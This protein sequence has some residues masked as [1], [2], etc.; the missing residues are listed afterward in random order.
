MT[1]PAARTPEEIELPIPWYKKPGGI[2]ALVVGALLVAG[3]IFGIIWATGGDDDAEV[4]TAQVVLLPKD[5][6]GAGLDQGF[7][8]DVTGTSDFPK[9]YIWL[10]PET[11]AGIEGVSGSSGDSDRVT[12]AWAPAADVTEPRDWTSTITLVGNSP[13]GFTPPGPVVECVLARPDEQNTTVSMDVVSDP[14][15]PLVEQVVTYTFPNHEFLP[16]DVVTCE[17]VSLELS[18]GDDRPRPTTVPET[19][20]PETLHDGARDDGARD[21]GARDQRCARRRC[22]R[23]RCPRRPCRP[24]PPR[25]AR[26]RHG[27]VAGGR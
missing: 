9:S 13:G 3:L 27:G 1:A 17:L 25:R 16:G 4:V 2:A 10:E 7:V 20:V 18:A 8:A 26:D 24:R 21:D 15:D 6:T 5:S 11:A 23:R 14:P 12:F 22:R 19:T